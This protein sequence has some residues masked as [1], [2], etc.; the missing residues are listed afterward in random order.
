MIVTQKLGQTSPVDSNIAERLDGLDGIQ[1]ADYELKE[2]LG[3]GGYGEVWR[4]IG[5]GGLAKA[6]KILYGERTGDHAQA[7]LKALER[8]RE[9]RHPF[10]LNI[11]RIEVVN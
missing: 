3:S 11:E 10:L 7:E 9:L 4:A 1:L 2:R 6:V 5:P 8:M